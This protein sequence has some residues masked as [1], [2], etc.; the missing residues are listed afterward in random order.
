MHEQ[1]RRR[2]EQDRADR[3]VIEQ[4]AAQLRHG[5]ILA[6]YAG[7]EH[8]HLATAAAGNGSDTESEHTTTGLRSRPRCGRACDRPRDT[9]H[10]GPEATP[11]P[12]ATPVDRLRVKTVS[13]TTSAVPNAADPYAAAGPA[14]P[15]DEHGVSTARKTPSLRAAAAAPGWDASAT[16]GSDRGRECGQSLWTTAL[17]STRRLEENL[18]TPIQT[19]SRTLRAALLGRTPEPASD[20]TALAAAGSSSSVRRRNLARRPG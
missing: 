20:R 5:A 15:G 12:A 3:Q 11:T 7:M 16:V 13:Q 14:P 10:F 18:D 1:E 9:D 19:D 4:A 2:V 17:V 6:G 8:K